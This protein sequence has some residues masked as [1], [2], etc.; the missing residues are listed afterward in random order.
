MNCT[1]N[2]SV[3][4][5]IQ[6]LTVK[7]SQVR[8]KKYSLV[9]KHKSA[10][11]YKIAAG[12]QRWGMEFKVSC[13]DRNCDSCSSHHLSKW[14]SSVSEWKPQFFAKTYHEAFDCAKE[15]DFSYERN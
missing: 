13:T 14:D 1:V 3:S 8:Q 15:H 7:L 5:T 12:Y 2:C 11:I 6:I 4:L 9:F 10:S